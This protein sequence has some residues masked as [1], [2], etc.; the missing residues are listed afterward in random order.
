M[1]RR[2]LPTLSLLLAAPAFA[3]DA[4]APEDAAEEV[5]TDLNGVGR[6]SIQ[7]GWR[8]TSNETLYTSWYGRPLNAG[9]PRA[10]EAAGG[11]LV[12]GS[13]AFAI[14]DMVELGIDLFATGG[15]LY[16]NEREAGSDVITERRFETLSFGALVGLRFQTVLPEVGPYGLVPFAGIL[17]GPSLVSSKRQG[18]KVQEATTQ[19]WVGSLGATLRL[20]P[21]WGLT[22][23]Y[24][25]AFARGPVVHPLEPGNEKPPTSSFSTGGNWLTLG[26]TYSFPAEPTRPLPSGL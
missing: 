10:R 4:Q 24:R 6:I 26:V 5:S 15:R 17:T 20:S 13:F 7:G 1:L 9:L 11:P 25:L 22:A 8:V 2:L 23:E 12:V 3:Q 19:A 14:T 21:R 16:L 18:D